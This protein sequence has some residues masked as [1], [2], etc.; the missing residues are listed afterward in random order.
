MAK[1][2][3]E[4]LCWC[5]ALKVTDGQGGPPTGGVIAPATVDAWEEKLRRLFVSGDPTPL[6]TTPDC[7]ERP[8]RRNSD[9]G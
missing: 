1:C 3:V 8:L 5:N 2:A 6:R 7:G 9:E 4:T